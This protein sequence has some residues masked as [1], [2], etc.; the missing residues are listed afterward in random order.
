MSASKRK[1]TAWESRVVAYLRDTGWPYAERRA[2]T[3]AKDC[4]DVA[5]IPGVVIEA[6][7]AKEMTLAKWM[8]EIEL[9]VF[10]ADAEVGVVWI[11]RRGYSSPGNGYVVMDGAQFVQLLN[12]AGL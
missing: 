9:E 3:G 8:D 4:G 12:K 11:H 1:G 5:G 7:N 2:L 6:K 10:N